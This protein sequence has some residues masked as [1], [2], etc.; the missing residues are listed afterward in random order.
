M[1]SS[2]F[3]AKNNLSKKEKQEEEEEPCTSYSHQGDQEI[4]RKKAPYFGEENKRVESRVSSRF[5]HEECEHA[6]THHGVQRSHMA[7]FSMRRKEEEGIPEKGTLS[8]FLHEYES[9]THKF[10]DH[11]SFLD[12]CKIM[13]RRSK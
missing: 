2:V 8:G 11:I 9:Q 13:V 10:R 7:S 5:F 1:F 3:R 12:F 6:A 4:S